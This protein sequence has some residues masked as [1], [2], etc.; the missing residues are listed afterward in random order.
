MGGF[1]PP[2]GGTRARGQS[3]NGGGGAHEG[4]HRPYGE[5]LTLIEYII[6]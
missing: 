1:V 4:G 6:N 2:Y 3:V 5:D